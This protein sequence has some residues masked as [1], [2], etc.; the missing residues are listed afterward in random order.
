VI[1]SSYRKGVIY[2]LVPDANG[3]NVPVPLIRGLVTPKAVSKIKEIINDIVELLK[4]GVRQD[5]NQLNA[6]LKQLNDIT[7]VDTDLDSEFTHFKIHT[8]NGQ[9]H[10]SSGDSLVIIYTKDKNGSPLLKPNLS[11]DNDE[12]RKYVSSVNAK[13]FDDTLTNT[14][15]LKSRNVSLDRLRK[16]DKVDGKKVVSEPDEWV[17]PVTGKKMT[18][19]KQ[20]LDFV[21]N[22]GILKTDVVKVV[23]EKGKL[24]SHVQVKGNRPLV[25]SIDSNIKETK[26]VEEEVTQEQTTTEQIT[27]Q[28]SFVIEEQKDSLSNVNHYLKI[29]K[30][31]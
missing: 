6:L 30:E 21:F 14:L 29:L 19:A 1:S 24:I 13:A 15:S 2:V 10:Y 20:Y 3:V 11:I 5:D 27:E 8:N 7:Y 9:I 26:T 18:S 25:L 17:E 23:D 16:V 4:K 28:Q 12:G 31:R 22:Q